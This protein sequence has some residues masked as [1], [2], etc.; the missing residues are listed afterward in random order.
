MVLGVAPLDPFLFPVRSQVIGPST[1]PDVR[2]VG[3]LRWSGGLALSSDDDRFG[4]LSGGV[5]GL[6]SEPTV[7]LFVSDCGYFVLLRPART[8]D[9]TLEGIAHARI[10]PIRDVD[11]RPLGPPK[12]QRRT[13]CAHDSDA[14]ELARLPDGRLVVPLEQSARLLVFPAPSSFD[15]LAVARPIELRD[16]PKGL[17]ARGDNH[18]IEALAVLRDG[19]LLAISE[20]AMT[21]EKALLAATFTLEPTQPPTRLAW[22]VDGPYRPSAAAVSDVGDLYVLERRFTAWPGESRP[23]VRVAVRRVAAATLAAGKLAPTETLAVFEG[24]L[25]RDNAEAIL[26]RRDL[27]GRL[28]LGL[29]SDDNYAA[30]GPQRTLWQELTTVR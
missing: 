22:P 14:E 17:S 11:R 10:A 29:V 7:G 24:D 21:P 23:S 20:G 9:D 28:V 27:A 15:A 1:R 25:T 3:H 2:E 18:G 30:N 4:G 26:L 12:G 19:R 13:K 5:M 16:H 8:A 6:G